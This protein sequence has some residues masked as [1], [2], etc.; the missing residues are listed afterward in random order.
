MGGVVLLILFN[1]HAECKQ[2]VPLGF[3]WSDTGVMI[4]TDIAWYNSYA[5]TYFSTS[6][7]NI[8]TQIP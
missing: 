5:T 4:R 2:H 1:V 6:Y 3:Y 7:S 8:W